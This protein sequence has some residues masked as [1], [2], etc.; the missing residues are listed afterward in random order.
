[1]IINV[2]GRHRDDFACPWD[3]SLRPVGNGTWEKEAV[4]SWW[5]RCGGGVNGLHRQIAEQW[6]FRHWD[7]TPYGDLP[8]NRLSWRLEHWSHK[9]LDRVFLRA[10]FGRLTPDAD[11]K[12]F[13]DKTWE[14]HKSLNATGTWDYPILVIETPDGVIADGEHLS[15]VRFCLIEGH[16]RYRFLKAWQGR[17]DTAEKHAVFVLTMN[18]GTVSV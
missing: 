16:Q 18:T 8:L 9:D 15:N 1:V 6:I 13:K 5:E 7:E 14:P 11:Y 17:A 2:D 3:E 12:A 4:D 10:G